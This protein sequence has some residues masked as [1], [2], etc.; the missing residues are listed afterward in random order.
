[1]NDRDGLEA[2][3]SANAEPLF[4]TA[5][6]LT[7][8]SVEAEELVQDTLVRLFPT[9]DKV[10][11]AES[12]LAYVRRSL[13]NRFISDRRRARNQDISLS[14]HHQSRS[15]DVAELVTDHQTLWQLM[16]PLSRRQQVALVLRHFHGLAD[17]EIAEEL[18]CRTATVRSLIS[19][20]MASMRSVALQ[21]PLAPPH[22]ESRGPRS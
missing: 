12:P 21:S 15:P 22:A 4:R 5:Y 13:T 2:F 10:M 1:M 6:L 14:E 7:R 9:W 16:R 3:L 11:A 18:G 19:R 8:N 20:G 17:I